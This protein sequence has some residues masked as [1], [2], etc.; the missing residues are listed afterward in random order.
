VYTRTGSTAKVLAKYRPPV[1]IIALTPD[2]RVARRLAVLWGTYPLHHPY[3]EDLER[4][5]QALREEIVPTGMLQEDDLVC[6]VAGWP[7]KAHG[8]INSLYMIRLS[9]HPDR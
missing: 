2:V 3:E 9:D 1:P 4:M 8:F 5:V 7:K 6:L